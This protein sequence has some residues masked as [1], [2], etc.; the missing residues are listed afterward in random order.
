MRNGGHV[1]GS[2]VTVRVSDRLQAM[3]DDRP[4]DRLYLFQ[5]A[6]FGRPF[7]RLLAG[8]LEADDIAAA[9]VFAKVRT[10]VVSAGGRALKLKELRHSCV[11]Q[12]ARSECTV[13]EIV[14]ITGHKISSAE[15]ILQKYLPRDSR[16]AENAQRKRGIVNDDGTGSLTGSRS[17]V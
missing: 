7:A 9:K 13:P 14:S 16:V 4:A 8:R 6:R 12:L 10:M 17:A 3:L 2:K 1:T 11:V 15:Q 5:D